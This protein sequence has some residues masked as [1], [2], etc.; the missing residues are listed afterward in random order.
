[1]NNQAK[2]DSY[3]SCRGTYGLGDVN[4]HEYGWNQSSATNINTMQG[5]VQTNGIGTNA[6]KLGASSNAVYVL[7]KAIIGVGGNTATDITYGTNAEIYGQPAA[8]STGKEATSNLPFAAKVFDAN[9]G[10]GTTTACSTDPLNPAPV[11]MGQYG[12]LGTGNTWNCFVDIVGPGDL[13]AD[14][15]DTYNGATLRFK[16]NGTTNVYVQRFV[17][18][19]NNVRFD[20]DADT[21]VKF[22]IEGDTSQTY[23]FKTLNDFR[24]NSNSG[25]KNPS[26]FTLYVGR[27]GD[28]N[29]YD[30]KVLIRPG[31]GGGESGVYMG[32]KAPFSTVTVDNLGQFYGAIIGKVVDINPGADIHYDEAM[33]NNG[34]CSGVGGTVTE[35]HV[36]NWL[37]TD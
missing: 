33:V 7:G 9:P 36:S 16:G 29:N 13:H 25:A 28:T 12:T 22:H 37:Q 19:A 1:M 14:V 10:A 34:S 27:D 2:A 31:T 26:K 21:T 3:D 8:T 20:L 5:H 17:N 30:Y 15:I 23:T 24:V 32:I 18:L 4:Y 6:I 11:P 35:S